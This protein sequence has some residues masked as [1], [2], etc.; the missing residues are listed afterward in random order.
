MVSI[1]GPVQVPRTFQNV[2]GNVSEGHKACIPREGPPPFPGI[3]GAFPHRDCRTSLLLGGAQPRGR[4]Y[5]G[6]RL[7]RSSVK[8]GSRQPLR[9]GP[10]RAVCPLLFLGFFPPRM[11]LFWAFHTGAIPYTFSSVFEIFPHS[12]FIS[13]Y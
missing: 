6:R 5:R 12:F 8:M 11:C 1:M 13:K 4:D 2:T 10:P 9:S 3:S 7:A